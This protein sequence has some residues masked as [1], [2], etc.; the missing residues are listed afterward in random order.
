MKLLE[1]KNIAT[2]LHNRSIMLVKN[3]AL[4]GPILNLNTSSPISQAAK[5][6]IIS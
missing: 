2:K 3:I 1:N 5:T 4:D 6:I